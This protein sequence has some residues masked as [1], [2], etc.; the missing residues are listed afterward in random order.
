MEKSD[1][2]QWWM[3]LR[4]RFPDSIRWASADKKK[5][6]VQ[7]IW[8]TWFE[9]LQDCDLQDC[10]NASLAIQRG[11]E[12]WNGK[13][14]NIPQII[15]AIARKRL[16]ERN[17]RTQSTP[18]R[19]SGTVSGLSR[20]LA[21]ILEAKTNGESEQASLERIESH[22]RTHAGKVS[23]PRFSCLPCQD[24]GMRVVYSD[25]ILQHCYSGKP[26]VEFKS[27]REAV[28]R[29]QCQRGYRRDET[30][31]TIPRYS[32]TTHCGALRGES[33]EAVEKHIKAWLAE[34]TGISA[35]MNHGNEVLAG[36]NQ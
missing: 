32:I 33:D 31:Q 23:Q 2:D 5:E 12:A 10:L 22:F 18:M 15:R 35:A 21:E 1:F 19:K 7:A 34:H 16:S 29:C 24:S 30:N 28:C 6:D 26:L 8:K 27:S 17:Q 11:D 9:V 25:K 3:D 13:F 14:E 4:A 36:W 20:L